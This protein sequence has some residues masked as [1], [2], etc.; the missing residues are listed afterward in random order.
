[1]QARG[2]LRAFL[3]GGWRDLKGWDLPEFEDQRASGMV[4]CSQLTQGIHAAIG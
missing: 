1:M 2:E 3:E 4:W